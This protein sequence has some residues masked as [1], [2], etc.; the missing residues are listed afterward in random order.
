MKSNIIDTE[1]IQMWM[2]CHN[3][4]KDGI[5]VL[6][7]RPVSTNIKPTF[8]SGCFDLDKTLGREALP[9]EKLLEEGIADF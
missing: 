8:H 2:N 9:P 1:D 7:S 5:R 6:P 4:G 3:A